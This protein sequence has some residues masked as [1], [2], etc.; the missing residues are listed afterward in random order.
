[1]IFV[2]CWLVLWLSVVTITVLLCRTVTYCRRL[3]AA[4]QERMEQLRLEQKAFEKPAPLATG[5]VQ[6]YPRSDVPRRTLPYAGYTGCFTGLYGAWEGERT[7]QRVV[8][9]L[10]KFIP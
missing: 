8:K 9:E 10:E 3:S 1:M 6:E 2:L 7:Q 5:L 4:H